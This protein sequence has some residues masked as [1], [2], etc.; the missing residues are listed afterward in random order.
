MK[1]KAIEEEL[2]KEFELLFDIYWYK[3]KPINRRLL[4][5]M[6]YE[7]EICAL[8]YKVIKELK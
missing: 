2:I 4:D 6:E 1:C 5:N 3:E 7:K 8:F